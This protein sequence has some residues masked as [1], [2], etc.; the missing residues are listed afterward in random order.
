MKNGGAGQIANKE[1]IQ[2]KPRK[3]IISY[4]SNKTES[5]YD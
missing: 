2:I 1:L 4:F 5:D 3:I